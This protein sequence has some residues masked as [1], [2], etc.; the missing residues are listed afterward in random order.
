MQKQGCLKKMVC[1]YAK[2]ENK[3]CNTEGEE[4]SIK[5]IYGKDYQCNPATVKA[6]KELDEALKDSN[7]AK[8]KGT[9]FSNT[10]DFE[11][12]GRRFVLHAML[13]HPCV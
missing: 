4:C 8:E 1:K 3:L 5:H 9:K 12:K 11:C 6:C 13:P 10:G 7:S 2:E